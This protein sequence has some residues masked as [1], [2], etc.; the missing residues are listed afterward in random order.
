MSLKDKILHGFLKWLLKKGISRGFFLWCFLKCLKRVYYIKFIS[1]ETNKKNTCTKVTLGFF[2]CCIGNKD[3]LALCAVVI[4]S[5]YTSCTSSLPL[6]AISLSLASLSLGSAAISPEIIL[7]TSST[8]DLYSSTTVYPIKENI[9][10]RRPKNKNVAHNLW[11]LSSI[12]R[13]HTWATTHPYLF[14]SMKHQSFKRTTFSS[15][16]RT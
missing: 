3:N 12:I 6:K 13:L 5:H 9:L 10:Q 16:M 8:L 2:C 1:A 11:T 14:V 4:S 15:K 7:M